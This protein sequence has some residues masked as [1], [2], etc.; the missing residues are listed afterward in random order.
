MSR[1]QAGEE[2]AEEQ[3]LGGSVEAHRHDAMATAADHRD[4]EPSASRRLPDAPSSIA[5]ASGSRSGRGE[6]PGQPC[7][8]ERRATRLD[9]EPG[10]DGIARGYRAGQRQLDQ[11]R[12]GDAG[13]AAG[14]YG[15]ALRK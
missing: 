5:P 1:T 10:C 14:A 13:G 3:A 8:S 6:A 11:R 9:S 2:G 12:V 15:F 7:R 4:D